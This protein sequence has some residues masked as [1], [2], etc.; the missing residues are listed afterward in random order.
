MKRLALLDPLTQLPNRRFLESKLEAHLTEARGTGAS[1]GL[2]F[3][4]IDHFK[5]FNDLYGHDVGD[6]VLCSVAN[7]L[8]GAVRPFDT[9]GRWGGEEF[10]G[11]FPNADSHHLLGIAERLRMLVQHSRVDTP[12]GP[13]GATVSLG[14]VIAAPQ[15]EASSL[16]TRADSLMYLSK[17]G[18]RNRVSLE[19]RAMAA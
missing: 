17:Q 12:H 6:Q 11:L 15:D 1:F 7:T 14:G 5:E 9:V 16:L 2:L 10:L 18:G 13:L 3:L 8:K 19:N 4:D